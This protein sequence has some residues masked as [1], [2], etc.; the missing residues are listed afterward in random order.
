MTNI[1]YMSKI[2]FS[3]FLI[4]F[5]FKSFSQVATEDII[6]TDRPDLTE[7][8]RT[9]PHKSIQIETGFLMVV[10]Q[11]NEPTEFKNILY[12]FPAT[13][14]RFGIF[15]NVEL[16]LFNQ[17][18]NERSNNP[19]LILKERSTYGIDNLQL[20][21]KINITTEKGLRPEIALLSHI[22]LPLGS[23][24]F[25][26]DKTLFNLVFSLSHTLSN[27]FSLGYNLGWTS[28]DINLKGS[29]TYTLAI[30]YTISPKLGFYAE[31]YGALQNLETLTL[32]LD[33]GFAYL[34]K[35]N[36]QLDLSAGK[37]ITENDYFVSAGFSLLIPEVF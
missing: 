29:G 23:E 10:E 7:S 5:A 2:L 16:R 22:V 24:Q 31:G 12:Q 17:F 11:P 15:E 27:K 4:L 19:S 37:S 3:S 13:L 21:T 9:V 26:N 6:I 35:N 18:V 32:G 1:N 14:V 36:I 30:G 25:K 8:S 33:G 20:G 34:L 28:N